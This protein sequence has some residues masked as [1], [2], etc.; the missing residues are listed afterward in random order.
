MP[1]AIL[2]QLRQIGRHAVGHAGYR[3]QDRAFND[4][5]ASTL[6]THTGISVGRPWP[7]SFRPR[8]EPAL[9]SST[10]AA[11]A[12]L[13]PVSDTIGGLRADG[14][15]A[16]LKIHWYPIATPTEAAYSGFRQR[17]QR[18]RVSGEGERGIHH[19]PVRS[20][21]VIQFNLDE[22]WSRPMSSFSRPWAIAREPKANIAPVLHAEDAASAD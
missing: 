6:V 9:L 2:R 22:R 21:A 7:R 17:Y 19:R 14:S 4:R 16:W 20:T 11:V 10:R 1:L 15:L 5:F 13:E 12:K 18:G 3:L 8:E